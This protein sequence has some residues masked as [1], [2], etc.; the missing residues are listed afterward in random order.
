MTCREATEKEAREQRD[1][2]I[3]Y[4]ETVKE[5]VN[6]NRILALLHEQVNNDC[7]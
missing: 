5:E 2:I 3:S 6:G 4:K 1:R 7:M